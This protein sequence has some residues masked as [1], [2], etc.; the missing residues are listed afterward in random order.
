MDGPNKSLK[1][2]FPSGPLLPSLVL[3]VV[4]ALSLLFV[5]VLLLLLLLL[6]VVHCR[7]DTLPLLF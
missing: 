5:V 2:T 1:P 7:V 3:E 6:E 4:N